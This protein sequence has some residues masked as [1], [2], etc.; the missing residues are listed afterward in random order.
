MN[1]D[2]FQQLDKVIHEKSRMAIM[3]PRTVVSC[4]M[5][6]HELDAS[7][8]GASRA[9]LLS[10]FSVSMD[11]AATAVRNVQTNRAKG[12]ITFKTD[13]ATQAIVDGWPK[14]THSDKAGA[15]GFP[16]DDN[17]EDVI[18]AYIEDELD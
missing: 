9:L 1:P 3:S 12:E 7:K 17:I 5:Y 4:F 10:G 13:P 8:L 11:A 15:L 6:M 2:S 14:T 18:A 16:S